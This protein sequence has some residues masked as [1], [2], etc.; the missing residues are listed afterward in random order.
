M[1]QS[2]SAILVKPPGQYDRGDSTQIAS[3]VVFEVVRQA[4]ACSSPTAG[5]TPEPTM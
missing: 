3:I 1:T 4:R 5:V 2:A